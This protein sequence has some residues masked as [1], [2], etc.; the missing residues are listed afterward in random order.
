MLDEICKN[1]D[2]CMY[3]FGGCEKNESERVYISIINIFLKYLKNNKVYGNVYVLLF[4][5]S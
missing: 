2:N 5:F 3:F 4:Y 1:Y